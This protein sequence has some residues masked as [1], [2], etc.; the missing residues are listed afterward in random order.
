MK[1]LPIEYWTMLGLGL[2]AFVIGES[3]EPFIA[4]IIVIAY[5]H[6]VTSA[7]VRATRRPTGPV[8]PPPAQFTS[9]EREA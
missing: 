2:W 3:V 7:R 8:V 1:K 6:R 4:G 5:V 9:G